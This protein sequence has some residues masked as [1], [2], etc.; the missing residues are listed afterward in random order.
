MFPLLFRKGALEPPIL[1]IAAISRAPHMLGF[2][3]IG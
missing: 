3:A 1:S 2:A